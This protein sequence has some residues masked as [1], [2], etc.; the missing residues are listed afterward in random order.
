MSIGPDLPV[1]DGDENRLIQV[2]VNLISNAVKFTDQGSITCSAML[3]GSH[4]LLSVAD[5]GGGIPAEHLETVFEK[6]TQSGDTLTDKPMGTGLG[7]PICRQIVEHHGGTIWLESTLG[8]GTTAFFT[9]AVDRD[10]V[11]LAPSQGSPQYP[12][13]GPSQDPPQDPSQDPSL[14]P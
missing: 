11:D 8:S 1:I 13:Q 14:D 4:V 10:T 9:L 5:T 2:L 6:F 3:Q 12:S 7:L